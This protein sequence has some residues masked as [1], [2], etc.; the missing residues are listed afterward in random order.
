MTFIKYLKNNTIKY[1]VP[2]LF[3]TG[4]G[5]IEVSEITRLPKAVLDK[6]VTR[7]RIVTK[8]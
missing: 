7:N 5:A 8:V 2:F 3:S 4:K 1:L 6:A